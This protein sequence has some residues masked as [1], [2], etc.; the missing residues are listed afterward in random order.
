MIDIMIDLET[1]GNG[2]NAAIIAI[3]AVEFD[4][5]EQTIGD[6]FHVH[7][8]LQSAVDTGGVMDP[9]TVIWWMQQSEQARNIFKG[10]EP[11]HIAEALQLFS[12]WMGNRGINKDKLLVWGC[13]SDFDNV[14]LAAAYRRLNMKTPW[15]FWNNRCYRTLKAMNP[16][17]KMQRTGTHHNAVDDAE[18]QARHL[19]EIQNNK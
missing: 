3:G 13:G 17:I 7:V 19:I 10:T 2:P 15:S 16:H 11:W 1:M 12:Q 5:I 4:P 6:R 9:S 8:D 18:S 14:I